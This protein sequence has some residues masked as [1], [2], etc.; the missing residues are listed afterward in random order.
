MVGRYNSAG[1][2]LATRNRVWIKT[3]NTG[4]IYAWKAIERYVF[5]FT[6]V[7]CN[8]IKDEPIHADN[9]NESDESLDSTIT[10]S[11]GADEVVLNRASIAG[12]LVHRCD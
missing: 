5:R 6:Q 2:C 11:G 4:V 9:V 7:E 1:L 12:L 10:I 8:N 3:Y